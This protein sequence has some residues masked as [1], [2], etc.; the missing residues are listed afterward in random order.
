MRI[1]C[2]DI[3]RINFAFYV[4]DTSTT[5]SEY[6]DLST[7]FY[8]LPKKQQRR[9][10]GE[11]N[12]NVQQIQN[13]M[14]KLGDRVYM[15]V[16][17]LIDDDNDN[18]FNNDVRLNMFLFLS[19]Y[20]DLWDTCD[21]FLIEEQYYNPHAKIKQQ[22]GVNKDAILLGE[23]CYSYFIQNHY[24][25]RDV[26]YF[27]A[28]LKTQTL[29]CDDYFEY[30][31]KKTKNRSFRKAKKYDRKIW[32]IK[33][34]K[35]IFLLRNDTIGHSLLCLGESC[36]QKQDDISDCVIMCQSHVFKKFILKI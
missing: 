12:D 17:N 23:S 35:E 18:S 29:G 31:D 32:S 30:V 25:F 26:Q 10:R 36:G 4:E 13:E 28:A 33:K 20:K 24:P 5:L 2:F 8:S 14:F 19:E 15:K 6:D 1:A 3:G 11:M 9:F 16:V 34:T 7:L 27:K 22:R 21:I